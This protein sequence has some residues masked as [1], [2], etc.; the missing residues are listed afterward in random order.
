MDNQHTKQ[1]SIPFRIALVAIS[2]A[3][4]VAFFPKR[5]SVSYDYNEGKPWKY[6]QI[7]AEYDFPIYKSDH[8]IKAETDSVLRSF[9]PY[10]KYEGSIGNMQIRNFEQD[11][12][13]GTLGNI[14]ANYRSY[15]LQKLSE[16]YEAGIMDSH[17]FSTVMDSG[18]KSVRIVEGT[19]ATSMAIKNIFTIR[20]AYVY[21]N[22]FADS[23][24]ISKEVLSRCNIND[25]LA[26][27]LSYDE[28]KTLSEKKELIRSITYS[29][30]MVVGGQKII[31]RGEIVDANTANIIASMIKESELRNSNKSIWLQL[32]GKF[33]VVILLLS[34]FLIY[35]RLYRKDYLEDIRSVSL[36]YFLLVAFPII[37]SLISQNSIQYIY[38]IPMAAIAI[39]ITVFMDS[40]TAFLSTLI[41]IVLSSLA[42]QEP[43]LF[44]ITQ[45][46]SSLVAIYSLKQLESRSQLFQTAFLVT[47]LTIVIMLGY[48]FGQGH[49]IEMLDTSWYISETINGVL[50]LFVYPFMFL[51]EKVFGFT[52]PI[53]LIEISNVNHPLLREL[54]KQAQGTF[55]HSMQVANLASEVAAKVGADVLLVRT[56][57]LYHDIGKIKNATYFTENQTSTNL[58]DNL[59]EERSAQIIIQHIADG[60]ELAE[61]YHLPR[62]IKEFI[63]THHGLSMASYFYIQYKNKHPEENVNEQL[64]TYP[65][66]NPYT[67]EQ[68]ILM[69]ADSVEAASRSMKTIDDDSIRELVK[70]TVDSKMQSGLLKDCPVTFADV[71]EAK[72]VLVASL[73]TIYHTRISYPTLNSEKAENQKK[74]KNNHIFRRKSR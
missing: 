16:V 54:S 36:L 11:V 1:L 61:K 72:E 15:L 4:I 25:Y 53:T 55:N 12:A 24:N 51:M 6:G 40:R 2:A 58:H 47:A 64:F 38:C 50:L 8:T 73:K 10:F 45:I 49:T 65:G 42:L 28:R 59:P 3:L 37:T 62:V 70:K 63:M 30:G 7:I 23:A 5:T 32:G 13:R 68:A 43:Y 41:A 57:A 44:V 17:D 9:Q 35:L 33:L 46:F 52:S 60:L 66:P 67:K 56:G 39:F 48:E 20:S 69:I 21:I 71:E 31:D 22:S 26:E 27:N 74:K 19:K 29:S 18:Y 14:P 34:V